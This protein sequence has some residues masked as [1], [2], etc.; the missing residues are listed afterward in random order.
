MLRRIPILTPTGETHYIRV[1][2][3]G[4]STLVNHTDTEFQ[5][6]MLLHGFGDQ[7]PIC[8][9]YYTLQ[10]LRTQ[11]LDKWTHPVYWSAELLPLIARPS[12]FF[13]YKQLNQFK[14][15]VKHVRQRLHRLG[16]KASVQV[17]TTPAT[18]FCEEVVQRITNG[19][20]QRGWDAWMTQKRSISISSPF[21]ATEKVEIQFYK[22]CET[23]YTTNQ[24]YDELVTEMHGRITTYDH[25]K[26][27]VRHS[28]RS[29]KADPPGLESHKRKMSLLHK[30][31]EQ[32]I[33]ASV[34]AVETLY[35][36]YIYRKHENRQTNNWYQEEK[37]NRKR[38]DIRRKICEYRFRFLMF[39]DKGFSLAT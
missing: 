18:D 14:R 39:T 26:I 27:F 28:L 7:T 2:K 30:L 23:S 38:D 34:L 4:A 21:K 25:H 5:L 31:Q 16:K 3:S 15:F 10:N 24:L 17:P 22:D 6:S 36:R 32:D 35:C 37:R 8:P 9:C 33:Q 11:N 19:L 1:S 20:R 13:N 29:R 12:N